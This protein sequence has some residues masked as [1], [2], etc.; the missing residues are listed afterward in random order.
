MAGDL[1]P[2]VCLRGTTQPSTWL[3]PSSR[4]RLQRRLGSRRKVAIGEPSTYNLNPAILRL[5]THAIIDQGPRI[6][7]PCCTIQFY[8]QTILLMNL[9]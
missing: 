4:A 7:L 3:T 1:L 8:L 6:A 5:L 9:D 2:G